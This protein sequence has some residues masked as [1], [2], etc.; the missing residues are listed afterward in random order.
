[1]IKMNKKEI[2]N[3]IKSLRKEQDILWKKYNNHNI[4][5][6]LSLEDINDKVIEVIP[7]AFDLRGRKHF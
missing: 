5:I 1:M 3:L 6:T 7:H 2:K 4:H